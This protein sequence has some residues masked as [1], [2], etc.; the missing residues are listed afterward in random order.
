MSQSGFGY[1]IHLCCSLSVLVYLAY[2]MGVRSL[3]GSGMF[4]RHGLSLCYG[5]SNVLV[6][7][8][9]WF[10][11]FAL[12]GSFYILLFVRETQVLGYGWTLL[13]SIL[14]LAL[15][16]ILFFRIRNYFCRLYLHKEGLSILY[17]DGRTRE[18]QF[19]DLAKVEK[20]SR[21]LF[22][23]LYL[24]DRE[25]NS[26]FICSSFLMAAPEFHRF[27]EDRI[28]DFLPVEELEEAN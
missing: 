8:L 15:N 16:L 27:L 25:G 4:Q 3:A 22:Q 11:F 19:Y 20:V 13:I 24:Q 18:F 17:L 28:R 10:H 7:I 9:A 21:F 23:D 6:S 14:L 26:H 12:S 2:F 1:G 5:Y